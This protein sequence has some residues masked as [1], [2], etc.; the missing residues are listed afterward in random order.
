MTFDNFNGGS[1][2]CNA[3]N[4]GNEGA[5]GVGASHDGGDDQRR[6][7]AQGPTEV[8]PVG[9]FDKAP[10]VDDPLYYQSKL[11]ADGTTATVGPF[12]LTANQI[13]AW[14]SKQ[15]SND[16]ND[17]VERGQLRASTVITLK[18]AQFASILNLLNSG[19]TQPESTVRRF[20]PG[21]LQRAVYG[22]LCE[23]QSRSR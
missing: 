9:F 17:L 3:G 14:A 18:S 4:D 6:L 1:G 7:R 20:I 19:Q 8:Y 23:G 5:D 22:K 12:E 21:D 16:L 2:R 15:T 13:K 10:A 11:S